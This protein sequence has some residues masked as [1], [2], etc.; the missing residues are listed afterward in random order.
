[1]PHRRFGNGVGF[2]GFPY[3]GDPLAFVGADTGDDN[4][5]GTAQ[6]AQPNAPARQ[7]YAPQPPYAEAPFDEGYPA[8]PAPY[9]PQGYPPPPQNSEQNAASVSDGLD[10][11]AVTLVFNDG[12]QPLKVHS[13]ALTGSTILVTEN[14]HQRVIAVADLDLPATIAQNREA[15][16][17]FELPGGSR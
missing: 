7:D 10:H 9:A 11:P 14:G 3:Y 2:V 13:Y 6:Q 4:G 1:V 15:G 17:D 5:D 8:P 16:V 12:R